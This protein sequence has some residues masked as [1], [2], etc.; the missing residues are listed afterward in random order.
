MESNALKKS[1]NKSDASRYF[2]QVTSI[3]RWIVRIF[4]AV[5][6]F[7]QKTILILPKNFLNF[8]F[9]VVE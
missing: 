5:D 9:D 2:S 4:E 3:I 6:R 7:L 8:W 1:M